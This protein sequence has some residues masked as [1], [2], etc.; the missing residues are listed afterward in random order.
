MIDGTTVQLG[1]VGQTGALASRLGGVRGRIQRAGGGYKTLRLVAVTKGFGPEVALTAMSLGLEDLGESYAGELLGKAA[2]IGGPDDQR[3]GREPGAEADGPRWHFLGAV[4]RN[5]VRR[6]APHVHLWHGVTRFSEG[7]EIARWVPGAGVLVQV[8]PSPERRGVSPAA[9]RDLVPKLEDLGLDVR[10]LMAM[11]PGGAP[12]DSRPGFR[13]L[14]ELGATLGLR[15]LSMGMSDDLE[16]AVQEG[17]TII[18]LGRALF[19][20]RPEP[21]KLQECL[22]AGGG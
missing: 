3:G 10:G 2:R 19:G 16:V 7:A 22:L 14:A 8:A 1:D 21:E 13:R 20:P 12:E 11:G 4:Q 18:R 9:V 15:E 17:A 5:K 6:L